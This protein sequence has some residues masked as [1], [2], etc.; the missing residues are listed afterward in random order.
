MPWQGSRV[1][2]R[3]RPTQIP[4]P[5]KQPTPEPPSMLKHGVHEPFSALVEC[6]RGELAG[7][8]QSQLENALFAF[9]G[10]LGRD[11]D[12][13]APPWIPPLCRNR[14]NARELR[15]DFR[16]GPGLT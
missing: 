15:G 8:P 16:K 10:I 14:R 11:A 5:R 6:N 9:R 7:E 2:G 13:V 3:R 4:P 12:F 1:P